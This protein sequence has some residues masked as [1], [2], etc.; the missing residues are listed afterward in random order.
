MRRVCGLVGTARGAV[1]PRMSSQRDIT[2]KSVAPALLDWWSANGRKDLPWQKNPTRYR[3][4]VSEVMLQQTQ[5]STVERY[6]DRF[7]KSFPTVNDLASAEPD[8][9]LHLWSGLGYYARA[10][11]LH[12]AARIVA[13]SHD[14][15]LPDDPESLQSLPGIG[16]STAGAILALAENQ[17]QP[18]LD[19]NAKRVLAR[20]FGVNGWPGQSAVQKRL[21]SLAEDCTPAK[22]AAGYTQ[23]I[24]D[25]GATVCLRRNPECRSCPLAG[26]CSALANGAI[27]S[28]PGQRPKREKPQRATVVVMAIRDDG[29]ILLQRR[30]DSGI[31]GGLWSLP[32]IDAIER[33]PEWCQKTVGHAPI[34]MQVRAVV[35]HSF[36]HFDLDMTPVETRFAKTDARLMD[37][38]AWLWYNRNE[39]AVVGLAAP[40]ARL[41]ERIGELT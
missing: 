35:R 9:V 37:G 19:G 23:S 17:R 13:D 20:V 12:K 30:P 10:R 41:L 33:V 39:P 40:V 26:R 25:L 5:V 28:I 22:D 34:D 16:R 4:W 14:G 8:R 7:M 38:D 6:Y 3:V 31:W 32:E 18:I 11:N 1:I 27:D 29:A 2:V 21:W 36:T 24:M 15:E